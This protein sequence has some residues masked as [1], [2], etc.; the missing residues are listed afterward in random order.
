[1][2]ENKNMEMND[3]AMKNAAG[4]MYEEG[5]DTGT[6]TTVL[7]INPNPED[8]EFTSIWDECMNNGYRVYQLGKSQYAIAYPDFPMFHEG[9]V[10]AL[11]AIRGCWGWEIEGVFD[12]P[13]V[14]M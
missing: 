3:E 2:T 10:V 8:A 1:M 14:I 11:N 4:G 12:G 6:I 7:T 9:D 5:K 13:V